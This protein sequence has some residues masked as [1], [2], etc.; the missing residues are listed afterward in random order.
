MIAP[1][2]KL[3]STPEAVIAAAIDLARIT[4]RDVVYDIGCGDGRVL[5]AVGRETGA[6]CVGIEIDAERARGAEA[7]VAEAGLSDIV[8][9]RVGNALEE[10]YE[11]PAPTVLFL[12]LAP[13]GY[14]IILPT[15]RRIAARSARPLRVL[16]YTMAFDD[17]CA[18]CVEVRHVTPP[19][20]PSVRWPVYLSEIVGAGA[21]E[22]RAPPSEGAA[23]RK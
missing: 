20:Q 1:R 15:L 4:E 3:W 16:T 5:I 2:K 23:A 6:A 10:K 17:P 21:D 12:Y 11:D 13:R 19:H 22:G 8:D 7:R 9:V 18:R 14:R